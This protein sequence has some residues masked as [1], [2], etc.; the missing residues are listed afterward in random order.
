MRGRRT[1]DGRPSDRHGSVPE[2]GASTVGSS[3]RSW[4]RRPF[5]L[6][7]VVGAA[8]TLPAVLVALVVPAGERLL[9]FLVPGAAVV[10]PLSSLMAAWPGAVN[11]LLAAVA[12]GLL[13]GAAAA[14]LAHLLARVRR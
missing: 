8:V 1:R 13:I 10:R 5:V 9:P 6:G 12:N 11:L 14:C 2:R 4:W 7:F 3:T